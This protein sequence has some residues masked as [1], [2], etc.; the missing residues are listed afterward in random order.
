MRYTGQRFLAS[1]LGR[2]MVVVFVAC[3][4]LPVTGLAAVSYWNTRSNLR[5]Q[6]H[7]RLQQAT[8]AFGMSMLERLLFAQSEL[9]MLSRRLD[10]GG[11]LSIV[12]ESM[13]RF[14]GVVR[15]VDA[16]VVAGFGVPF[17]PPRLGAEELERLAS[18][19]AVASFPPGEAGR[20]LAVVWVSAASGG[21]IAGAL[22]PEY[23]WGEALLTGLPRGAELVVLTRDDRV[24]GTSLDSAATSQLLE[25]VRSQRSSTRKFEVNIGER[26][27]FG[28]RWELPLTYGFGHPGLALVALEDRDAAT[29]VVA[30]YGR[31]YLLFGAAAMWLVMLLSI[32]QIRR[33]LVPL[34]RLTE[35]TKRIARRDFGHTVQITSGDEFEDL[36]TS[37]NAMAGRINS[38]FEHLATMSSIER[39]ILSSLEL[40]QVIDTT[41]SMLERV[42][43]GTRVAV[44]LIEPDRSTLRLYSR[45]RQVVSLPCGALLEV[46]GAADASIRYDVGDAWPLHAEW[47]RGQG[48]HRCLELPL[49]IDGQP[50]GALIIGLPG[51]FLDADERAQLGQIASQLAVAI[52]NTRLMDALDG[53]KQGALLAL[54]RAVDA[55]ST[56]TQGHSERVTS[57][58]VRLGK[59]LGVGA[60]DLELLNRGGLVHDIGKIGVPGVILDKPGKLSAA[61]YDLMKEHPT[62]GARILEPIAAYADVL[63]I[64]LQHHERLDGRGYPNGIGGDDLDPNARITAVADVFDA[65]SSDRPYR[66]GM[67]L[68]KV[69]AII[70][71]GSGSHFD[72]GV[73]DALESVWADDAEF[74][75]RAQAA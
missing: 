41:I 16:E 72:P 4:A 5:E 51:G 34:E 54:A 28:G 2:R 12:H 26:G 22:E 1:R 7:D 69:M 24:L 66:A 39:G 75:L 67:P 40:E 56:W 17:D 70:R 13:G 8:K 57:L 10:A 60:T 62:I 47:L 27:Y 53:M 20:T 49:T 50:S 58:A 32:S 45:G 29:S 23:G 71:E 37:F 30:G 33:S 14:A 65:C 38:Q 64:V 73:V 31:D 3:A 6:S 42:N 44:T 63:P 68:E 19:G 15:V 18:G 21:L 59:E 48:A 11:D 43:Q 36:A 55:K 61:E 46:G 74:H 25:T 52:S 35:G 9:E